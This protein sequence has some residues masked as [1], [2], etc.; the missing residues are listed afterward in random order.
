V[1]AGKL[2]EEAGLKG[3]RIGDAQISEKHANFIVNRGRARAQ[4]ILALIELARKKVQ[5]EKGVWLE[6]EIQVIGE[7]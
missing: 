1:P 3:Y 4:D 6:T 7:D 5:Q 2:I